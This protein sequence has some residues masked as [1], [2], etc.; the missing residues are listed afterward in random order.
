METRG[1]KDKSRL[2]RFELIFLIAAATVTITFVSTCSPLYPFN[3]WDD[4]NVFFVLGR[5]IRHGLVPYRDLFDHKGPL[6]HFIFA[7]AALISDK[8]FIGVWII[9]CAA[10]SAFAITAWKTAKILVTPS[11]WMIVVMPIFLGIT[12]TIKMFNF[13]GNTEELCFPLLTIVF[14]IGLKSIVQKDGI[15][16]KKDAFICGLIS[17][18]L[19]WIKYSFLGFIFGLSVNIIIY[20]FKN[21]ELKRLWSL[22]WRFI[23]GMIA[24]SIPIL[25]YF[26]S[27]NA[28]SDLWEAYFK[29]NLF[30]YL[31][32]NNNYTFTE[33]PIIKNIILTAML[34]FKTIVRFP[35]FGA[36]I[37][38]SVLSL[39]FVEKEYRKKTVILFALTFIITAGFVFSKANAVF[40]YGYILSFCFP[41]SLVSLIRALSILEKVFKHFYL[42][43]LL[44]GSKLELCCFH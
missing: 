11:K 25:C 8:S 9:E 2:T 34:L 7:L 17:G 27:T 16:E 15:P 43:A 36:M 31:E 4:V 37:L 14:Y 32:K 18:V 10:A 20:S 3:P 28:L 33:I 24:V 35:A 6:L 22:I 13:G 5:S 30:L 38:A 40:Y 29:I 19:F 41:L 1:L 39:L 21:K 12:Y 44:P 26:I 23:I 42:N